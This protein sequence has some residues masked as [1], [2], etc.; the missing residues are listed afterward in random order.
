MASNHHHHQAQQFRKHGWICTGTDTKGLGSILFT[1]LFLTPFSSFSGNS[2]TLWPPVEA[3][4]QIKV[5]YAL[6]T[7]DKP[8]WCLSSP[9]L[10]LQKQPWEI[11]IRETWPSLSCLPKLNSFQLSS[12]LETDAVSA[13]GSSQRAYPVSPRTLFSI[14]KIV[15]QGVPHIYHSWYKK[16]PSFVPKLTLP[17]LIWCLQL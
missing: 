17:K 6:I 3:L 16:P 13:L 10:H 15:L 4:V 11:G 1:T 7:Q 12:Q 14:S 2:I 5:Q 9:R 8:S